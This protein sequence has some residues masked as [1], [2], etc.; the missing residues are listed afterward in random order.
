MSCHR[1]SAQN[2]RNTHYNDHIL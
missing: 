2:Q 1:K